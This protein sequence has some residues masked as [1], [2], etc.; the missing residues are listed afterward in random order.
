MANIISKANK[1]I[2]KKESTT[3]VEMV[4]SKIL[5]ELFLS[6]IVSNIHLHKP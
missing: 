6:M 2:E 1:E 4:D 5:V 3:V